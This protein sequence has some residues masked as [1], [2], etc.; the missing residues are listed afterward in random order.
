[1]DATPSSPLAKLQRLGLLSLAAL[2]LG[3][4]VLVLF[5]LN[6]IINF[7]GHQRDFA[8]DPWQANFRIGSALSVQTWVALLGICFGAISYGTGEAYTHFFDWWCSRQ[9]TAQQGLDY[10]RY[11]NSQLRAPTN[12]GFRGFP[13]LVFG[14]YAVA[15]LTV[16]T[17]I[18]Y[19][20]GVSEVSISTLMALV[21][22]DIVLRLPPV[23]GFQNGT[24][25]PGSAF[26]H[27]ILGNQTAIPKGIFMVGWPDCGDTLGTG[28]EGELVT[29]EI[30][31]TGAWRPNKPEDRFYMSTTEN[32]NWTRIKATN[33]EWLP[34][35][36]NDSAQATIEYRL[37]RNGMMEIQ[38][39]D[40]ATSE[41]RSEGE[42]LVEQRSMWELNYLVVEVQR[43][44]S[45]P[46]C[47]FLN[48]TG[49]GGVTVLK[50]DETPVSA[51]VVFDSMP[52]FQYWVNAMLS[53]SGTTP[54]Q[55]VSAFVRGAMAAWASQAGD[56]DLLAHLKWSARPF[57]QEERIGTV[58]IDELDRDNLEYPFFVGSRRG[59]GLY[60]VAAIV[61]L[62][63][64]IAAVATCG[65]R[66]WVGAPKVTSWMGQHFYLSQAGIIQ[67]GQEVEKLATGYEVAPD[68]VG[69]LHV[70]DSRQ[71][72][73]SSIVEL[74]PEK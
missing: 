52:E 8:S 61:F 47:G 18:G 66:I 30:I 53:S 26:H 70:G 44:V 36:T 34:S 39:A 38:W 62:V 51:E 65:I 63:I 1:M 22:E 72:L 33:K 73:L 16:I 43:R 9:A 32:R 2:S 10:A 50:W 60:K 12:I 69:S 48:D 57:G 15:L 4:V 13:R 29:K 68:N 37:L 3:G 40:L 5:S 24:L 35:T 41:A 67:A 58:R 23:D 56:T 25:S 20:F 45:S 55:G 11:L 59:T 28:D 71:P 49:T 54:Q 31:M 7:G 27:M 14:R 6:T 19:K 21:P 64:G 46:G 17:S 42:V 74:R